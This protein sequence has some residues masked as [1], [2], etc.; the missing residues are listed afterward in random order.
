MSNIDFDMSQKFCDITVVGRSQPRQTTGQQLIWQRGHGL[1]ERARRHTPDFSN[2][3]P[4][5]AWRDQTGVRL[6][7]A[8]SVMYSGGQKQ[9]VAVARA[10]VSNPAMVL[11]DEPT[12]A[13]DRDSAA[14]VVDLLER[15]GAERG[16]T[17]LL[18]THDNRI[19]DRADRILTLE[20]GR[21]VASKVGTSDGV[22]AQAGSGG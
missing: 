18:V 14:E 11:A 6:A 2:R 17:T 15:L 21:I 20:D 1:R 12:A 3:R 7:I 13:L 9:C 4:T 22:A 8:S 5:V 16:T 19:L 10:L